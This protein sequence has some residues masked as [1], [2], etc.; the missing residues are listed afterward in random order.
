MSD[1]V[2]AF[3]QRGFLHIYQDHHGESAGHRSLPAA[4][5]RGD[6][7]PGGD[8]RQVPGLH[9]SGEGSLGAPGGAGGNQ[10]PHSLILLVEVELFNHFIIFVLNAYSGLLNQ[11][12]HIA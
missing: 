1:S 3:I 6:E 4:G 9:Q 12:K 5:R 2:R 10:A 8:D 11:L 7:H